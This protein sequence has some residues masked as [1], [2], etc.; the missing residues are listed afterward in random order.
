MREVL[1][2]V[3][4]GLKINVET[5][6]L[7]A[8][9]SLYG[10]GQGMVLILGTGMNCGFH[11]GARMQ[12]PMPS[13][14]FVLGDEGSGADL[15]K[16]LLKDALLGRISLVEAELMFPE[17]ID[18]GRILQLVYRSPSPQAELASFAKRLTTEGV[19]DY[20]DRLVGARFMELGA[21]VHEFFPDRKWSG[22]K[23]VGSVAWGFR[24]RLHEALGHYGFRLTDVVKDPMGGLLRYH[25]MRPH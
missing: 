1:G 3:W 18:R 9:R 5:D 15:G 20:A 17:G 10:S 24:E 14:G 25:S 23:A 8:A 21:L 2:S 22:L 12:C 7:G 4:P 11:D 19:E 6:M 13:L 16:H